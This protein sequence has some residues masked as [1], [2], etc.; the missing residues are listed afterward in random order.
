LGG[1]LAYR[2]SSVIGFWGDIGLIGLLL[3]IA[4]YLYQTFYTANRLK[5]PALKPL[6][7]LVVACGLLLVGQSFILN[8]FEGNS[9]AL[10]LFWIL[11]GTGGIY[12][13]NQEAKTSHEV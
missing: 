9:F 7:H 2:S 10:N 8:V 6:H 11:C 4:V 3:V 5:D 1:S 13:R 12:M